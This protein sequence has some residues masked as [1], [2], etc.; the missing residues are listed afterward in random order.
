MNLKK[1]KQRNS[2]DKEDENKSKVICMHFQKIEHV[3]M[4]LLVIHLK[5]DVTHVSTTTQGLHEVA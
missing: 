1:G 4:D 2:S 5:M 3:D